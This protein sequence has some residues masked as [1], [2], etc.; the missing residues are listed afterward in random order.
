[1]I[2]PLVVQGQVP[3]RL[4]MFALV[5]HSSVGGLIY[6]EWGFAAVAWSERLVLDRIR[7][8][9]GWLGTRRNWR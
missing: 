1:V 4:R 5:L 2:D 8:Y 6:Y 9:E 3:L 7:S